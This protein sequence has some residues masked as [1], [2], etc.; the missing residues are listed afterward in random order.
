M[1]PAKRTVRTPPIDKK[2]GPS[3]RHVFDDVIV[4]DDITVR[5]TSRCEATDDG[6]PEKSQARHCVYDDVTVCNDVVIDAGD[7]TVCVTS[8][9]EVTDDG[10]PEKSQTRHCDVTASMM[11]SLSV[12]TSS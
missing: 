1:T 7:V 3:L 11:M 4:C 2:S 10:E 9:C 6:E 5:V 8:R 12:M